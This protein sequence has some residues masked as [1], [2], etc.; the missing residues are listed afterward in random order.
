MKLPK[1]I[2]EMYKIEDH[3]NIM[4]FH[5]PAYVGVRKDEQFNIEERD[6][7]FDISNSKCSVTV[8]KESRFM[9]VV[10]FH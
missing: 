1:E 5:N 6:C 7:V 10:V 8:W 9:H 4:S 2:I 3:D